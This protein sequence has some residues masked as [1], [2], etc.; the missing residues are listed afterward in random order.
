MQS[1]SAKPA[2][3]SFKNEVVLVVEDSQPNAAAISGLL[4]RLAFDVVNFPDG[5]E[6]WDWLNGLPATEA[7]KIKAIF[8]DVSMPKMN[9]LELLK[10]VRS[11]RHLKLVRF[12]FCSAVID[13]PVVREARSL[14]SDGYIVKRVMPSVLQKKLDELFPGRKANHPS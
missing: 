3:S 13:P 11:S 9:G 6:A 1:P 8:C 12:V 5:A 2:P 7:E 14:S 4:K 10:H